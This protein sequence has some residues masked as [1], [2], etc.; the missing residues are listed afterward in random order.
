MV[1]LILIVCLSGMPEI[2]RAEEP[3]VVLDNPMECFI[4]GQRIA[5]EWTEEHPK[6]RLAEWRCQ[7]G[8]R[9]KHALIYS[10]S[11]TG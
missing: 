4:Q 7:L 1:T 3:V 9:E 11:T 10:A 5:A 2:C 6:W 8:P